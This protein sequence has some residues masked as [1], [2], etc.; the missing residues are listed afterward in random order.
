M[1]K[2]GNFGS[3]W[4]KWVFQIIFRFWYHHSLCRKKHVQWANNMKQMTRRV[5]FSILTSRVIRLQG[6]SEKTSM[7]QIGSFKVKS[8]I[9]LSRA[10]V[11]SIF[12][13]IFGKVFY[14]SCLR[15]NIGT[16]YRLYLGWNPEHMNSYFCIFQKSD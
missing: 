7:R 5:E 6:K 12:Y 2:C 16:V 4:K 13:C 8:V 3:F 11:E 9:F 14:I 15:K 10:P 1:K